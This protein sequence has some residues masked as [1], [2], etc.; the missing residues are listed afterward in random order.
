MGR[1]EKN[2]KEHERAQEQTFFI[3]S[4]LLRNSWYTFTNFYGFLQRERKEFEISW[5]ILN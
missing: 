4:I 3:L 5:I 2:T 1:N